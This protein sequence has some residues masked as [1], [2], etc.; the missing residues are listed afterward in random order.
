MT[1]QH[2]ALTQRINEQKGDRASPS[3]FQF[4][5]ISEWWGRARL[6]QEESRGHDHSTE[7]IL[8]QT[9]TIS[10]VHPLGPELSPY[11]PS[12]VPP[13]NL[14]YFARLLGCWSQRAPR[15]TK[16]SAPRRVLG[17]HRTSSLPQERATP[18]HPSLR[19][20]PSRFTPRR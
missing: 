7:D 16:L 8:M 20:H 18:Y 5:K 13:N 10:T 4:M 9:P 11:P 1:S 15:S 6:D 3:R 19:S 17:N 2:N 14:S 12:C